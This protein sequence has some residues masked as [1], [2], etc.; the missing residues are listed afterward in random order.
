MTNVT[1]SSGSTRGRVSRTIVLLVAITALAAIW[2]QLGKSHALTHQ[3]GQTTGISSEPQRLRSVA[4]AVAQTSH[5]NAWGL[6]Q[7]VAAH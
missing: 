5:N 6:E 7:Y 2:V 1:R 3:G 4:G